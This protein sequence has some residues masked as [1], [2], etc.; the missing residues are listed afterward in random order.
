VVRAHPTV[1]GIYSAWCR[2]GENPVAALSLPTDTYL[3][4]S[5][6]NV[7][8]L[9]CAEV[10]KQA[11]LVSLE[12]VRTARRRAIHGASTPCLPS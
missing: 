12:E 9:S 4:T 1:P 11:G 10:V 2:V 6:G 5:A 3:D 7:A 8:G